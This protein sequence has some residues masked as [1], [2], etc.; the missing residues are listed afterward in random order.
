VKYARQNKTL[1]QR[2]NMTSDIKFPEELQEEALYRPI[3]VRNFHQPTLKTLKHIAIDT[4]KT[5]SDVLNA[6]GK[7][8]AQNHNTRW[9]EPNYLNKE[10]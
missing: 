5:L 10:E 4:G 7:E 6:A 1:T 8:Y 2:S 3:S 9:I